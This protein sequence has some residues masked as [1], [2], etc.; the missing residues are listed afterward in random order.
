MAAPNVSHCEI[1]CMLVLKW[2]SSYCSGHAK[3]REQRGQHRGGGHAELCR[4]RMR[5]T[6]RRRPSYRSMAM[7]EYHIG[8]AP[9]CIKNYQNRY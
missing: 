9:K 2:L 1:T 4:Q 6:R 5:H 8:T 3:E 7:L